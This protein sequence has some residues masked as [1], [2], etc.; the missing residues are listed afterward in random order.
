LQG[1]N[2]YYDEKQAKSSYNDKNVETKFGLHHY[3]PLLKISRNYVWHKRL[4]KMYNHTSVALYTGVIVANL[5]MAVKNEL[6][7]FCLFS[8]FVTAGHLDPVSAC[9]HGT[10]APS[11]IATPVNKQPIATTTLFD[12]FQLS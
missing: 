8:A 1:W 4:H 9:A 12:T 3:S 10:P 6:L 7:L 5:N 11:L 2:Y